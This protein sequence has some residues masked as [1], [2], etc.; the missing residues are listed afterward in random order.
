[1]L[2]WMKKRKI[3]LWIVSIL[4]SVAIWLYV[5]GVENPERIITVDSVKPVFVGEDLLSQRNLIVVG[6]DDLALRLRVKGRGLDV[7]KF[8]PDQVTAKLDLSDIS[9]PG[10]YNRSY[11]L[12][13]PS[14]LEVVDQVP[15]SANLNVENLISDAFEVKMNIE[16]EVAE[17]YIREKPVLD[18]AVVKIKGPES[19]VSSISHAAINLKLEKISETVNETFPFELIDKQGNKI[20]S[21]ELTFDVEQIHATLPVKLVKEVQLGIDFVNG[22]GATRENIEYS[23]DPPSI[24]V[25]GDQSLVQG[26]NQLTVGTIDLSTVITS[27]KLKMPIT[28]PNEVG[29]ISGTTEASVSIQIKGLV[30]KSLDVDQI[31]I[32]NPPPGKIARK[33]TQNIRVQI[34]GPESS[35]NQIEPNNIRAVADLADLDLPIGQ[36]KIDVI[37]TIDGF[38][39]SGV[40]GGGYSI[41]IEILPPGTPEVDGG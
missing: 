32:I 3:G 17:G 4:A 26:L 34:R 31:E 20:T 33:I 38:T 25:S 36:H 19:V 6:K 37:V 11:T 18:P 7:I 5:T 41:A 2:T 21:T 9:K 28:L 24:R 1:M 30:T 12:T 27:S 10:Q 13:L 23:I 29:N 14:N 39:D 16:G 35:V 15:Y 40:I 22:G 8:Q